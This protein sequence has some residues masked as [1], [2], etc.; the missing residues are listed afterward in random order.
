MLAAAAAAGIH[1]L[2]SDTS[3]PG[4]NN[5]SFNEGIPSTLQAGLLLI[6]RR[7]TDLYYSVSTP[8]QWVAEYNTRN[9]TNLDYPTLIDKVSTTLLGYLLRGENDPWMFHQADTRDNG[10][11][12]SL[13][14]DLLDAAFDKY[15][16]L[17]TVP[18]VSPTMDVLGARVAARAQFDTSGASATIA[19]D[20]SVTVHVATNA[21]TVP[22]TGLCSPGAESYAGDSI[23]YVA[24]TPGADVTVPAGSCNPGV[25]M[26]ADAGAAPPPDGRR[27]AA[28]TTADAGAVKQPDGGAGIPDAAPPPIGDGRRAPSTAP[29]PSSASPSSRTRPPASGCACTASGPASRWSWLPAAALLMA[30]LLPPPAALTTVC[31]G[32]R[33]D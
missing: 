17:M 15:A 19:A 9:S 23:S 21:A 29:T 22:V 27:R 20:G 7:P 32:A 24:V 12:H 8:A 30:L 1:Y 25:V 2:V 4:Y 10:G 3:Q 28:A 13:L 31:G 5:P 33:V 6:P 16:A 11:G 18:I 26:P 14:S